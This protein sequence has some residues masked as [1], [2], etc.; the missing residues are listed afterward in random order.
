MHAG[1]LGREGKFWEDSW[2][3][4]RCMRGRGRS[5]EKDIFLVV[6]LYWLRIDRKL[7][8]SWFREILGDRKKIML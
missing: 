8:S 1:V 3:G 6:N 7:S 5:E 2:V 4:S